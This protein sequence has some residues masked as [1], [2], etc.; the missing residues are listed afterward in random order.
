MELAL[1]DPESGFYT[2]AGGPSRRRDYITSPSLGPLFGAVLARAL[3]SWWR[4]LGAP[5]EFGVIEAGAGDGSLAKSILAAAPDCGSALRYTLVE[6]SEVLRRRHPATVTSRAEI[7]AGAP[8]GVIVANELLDNLPFRL[9]ERTGAGW[10]EVYVDPARRAV[11]KPADPEAAAEATRLAPDAPSNTRIPLQHQAAHWLRA[12]L[13]AVTR[14]RVVVID[15]ADTT[16]SLA[17]RSWTEWVR[18]YRANGP[19]GAPTQDQGQQDITCEVAIDQLTAAVARPPD[20]NT[21]QA[22]F[23]RAH[24]IDDLAARAKKEWQARA[25]VGDLAALKHKSRITEAAALTDPNGL[26]AFRVLEWVVSEP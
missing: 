11:L 26:G 1:Y 3:D 2:R 25:H 8:A 17:T 20:H 22:G 5:D 15:Y 14:G 16:P 12:A 10:Q 19:G 4:D 9:L 7:P 21:T 24:G 13:T 23:L 18:T 6:R